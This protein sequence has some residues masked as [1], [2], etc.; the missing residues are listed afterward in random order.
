MTLVN[1]RRSM[2]PY[3]AV[4]LISGVVGAALFFYSLGSNVPAKEALHKYSGTVDKLFI[5]DDLSGVQTGFMKPMNSIHFTLQDSEEIF[6]YPSSWPGYS[7]IYEQLSFY[8]DVWVRRT[9]ID[10]GEPMVVFRLEQKVPKNWIVAPFSISYEKIAE[11]QNRTRHSYVRLG[12]ILLACS[13]GFLLIAVLL[14]VWNRRKNKA[15]LQ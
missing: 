12:A 15:T 1:E 2:W 8:V 11:S 10:S 6:R 4:S 9:D 3:Y 5:S 7:K 14:G 13:A